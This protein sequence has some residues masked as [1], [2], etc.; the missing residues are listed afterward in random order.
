MARNRTDRRTDP[1]P[2]RTLDPVA[3]L[4]ILRAEVESK[5][6]K[7]AD[8]FRTTQ[9]WA[10]AWDVSREHATRLLNR[11]IDSGITEERYFRLKRGAI[12]RKVRHFKIA[13]KVAA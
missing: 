4:A 9:E 6:E 13:A 10:D 2:A 7:P 12:V 11:G 8:G 3:A 5:A 1:L